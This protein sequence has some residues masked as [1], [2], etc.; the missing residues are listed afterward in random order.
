MVRRLGAHVTTAGGLGT[1]IERA[2]LIGANCIQIFSSPPQQWRPS[3]HLPE[4][5][6][7]FKTLLE[8]NDISPVFVHGTYL[9]NLASDNP[10]S[11]KQSMKSLIEDLFFCERIGSNG[12]IFHM[13][14]HPLGWS[15]RKREELIGIFQ[16]ILKQSP[17]DSN[18][19]IENS[20]GGGTKIPKTLE[21]LSQIAGDLEN[22]RIQFCIDTA[23]AF[24]AGYDLRTPTD[25][26]AFVATV[27]EKIGWNSVAALHA[28]DSKVDLGRGADR[29]ENI[30]YGCIG[31][32]GFASL[33]TEASLK[34][35]PVILEVPGFE[36]EGPDRK[37]MDSIK[38]AAGIL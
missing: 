25:V 27:E 26:S 2:R 12:V 33:L 7:Q 10:L 38:R 24:A 31:Y 37:N 13:G 23:H 36:D 34:T 16:E 4:A 18:I 9:I 35:I 15:G 19:I 17:P 22:K 21:E 6:E 8:K 20:A 28:N 5:C 14:S 30:G 29:H 32:E 1:A 11:V 3:S